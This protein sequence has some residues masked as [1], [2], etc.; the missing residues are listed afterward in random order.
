MKGT[1]TQSATDSLKRTIIK[2]EAVLVKTCRPSSFG[3]DLTRMEAD[4]LQSV[5]IYLF[6]KLLHQKMTR[7]LA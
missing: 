6:S 2:G 1:N 7:N 3:E 4:D 5:T